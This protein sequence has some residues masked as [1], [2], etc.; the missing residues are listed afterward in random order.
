MS[1]RHYLIVAVL[2]LLAMLSFSISAQNGCA[3][4]NDSGSSAPDNTNSWWKFDETSGITATDS[5]GTNNGTV[6]GATWSDSAL[7][8]DGVNDY[9]DFGNVLGFERTESFSLGAWIKTDYAAWQNV[10]SK[11]DTSNNYRGYSM[12]VRN[13]GKLNFQILNTGSGI[14]GIE[15]YADA[16]LIDNAWHHVVATY[17]GSGNATGVKIYIDGTLRSFNIQQ[18]NL[19]ATI[20][21]SKPFRIGYRNDLPFRGFIYDAKVHN[22]V[23]SA[24]DIQA[25]YAASGR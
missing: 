15:G 4:P 12:F 5:S 25:D 11:Q 8:F 24:G 18:N 23:R 9:V 22:Y 21:N 1:K 6:Y 14:N 16:N 2:L 20:L 3:K 17:D 10:F 13:D 19:N 7:Y